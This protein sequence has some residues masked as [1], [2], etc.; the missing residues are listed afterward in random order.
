[1]TGRGFDCPKCHGAEREQRAREIAAA[2]VDNGL[3]TA[4]GAARWTV[5]QSERADRE[6]QQLTAELLALITEGRGN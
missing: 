5:E 4:L 1:M 3:A 2:L 6:R